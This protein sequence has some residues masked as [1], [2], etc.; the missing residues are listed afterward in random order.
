MNCGVGHRCGLDLVLLWLWHRLAA[1]APIQPLA[2]EPP[3]AKGVALTTI[4][5]NKTNSKQMKVNIL[6]IFRKKQSYILSK[7]KKA[8]VKLQSNRKNTKE[9][10]NKSIIL[11]GN[12]TKTKGQMINW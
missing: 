2:W 6:S 12:K 11:K 1:T 7:L 4:T 8:Q 5:F 3:Y 9:N 10:K